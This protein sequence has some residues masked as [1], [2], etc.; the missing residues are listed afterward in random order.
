MMSYLVGR[1]RC[2]GRNYCLFLQNKKPKIQHFITDDSNLKLRRR[3]DL[4]Q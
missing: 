1:Y 4:K 3:E 2:F